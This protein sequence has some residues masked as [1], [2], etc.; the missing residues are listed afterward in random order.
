M[1]NET[2][3]ESNKFS[4]QCY[5]HELKM[6]RLF[7]SKTDQYT[8]VTELNHK[9]RYA[10]P[11]AGIPLTCDD[12]SKD[13]LEHQVL[14]LV[15]HLQ[16]KFCCQEFKP[17][18]KTSILNL[19][20]F[21]YVERQ[22]NSKEANTCS[23]CYKVYENRNSRRRHETNVHLKTS[24]KHKCDACDRSYL[25]KDDLNFHK[26]SSHDHLFNISCEI[27]C[28]KFSSNRHLL[29]HKNRH[30]N[31]SKI[32]DFQCETCNQTFSYEKSL[33]RH[34]KE[35]HYKTKLNLDYAKL[36][37][38][39]FICTECDETFKRK[40][41]M[42]RHKETVHSNKKINHKCSICQKEFSRKDNMNRHIKGGKCE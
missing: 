8:I 33:L 13:V 17:F 28:A 22:L 20:D 10:T 29:Q 27:C 21:I 18:M 6:R 15:V 16:C 31:D 9:F 3:N 26:S 36:E 37:H 14:H 42:I 25:N 34:F 41:N 5:L 23:F 19:R 30:H 38:L 7:N 32:N 4:S 24:K 11:Y 1:K 2:V 35:V 12:C 39:I 40:S